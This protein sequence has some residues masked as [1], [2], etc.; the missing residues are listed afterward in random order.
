[1]PRLAEVSLRDTLIPSGTATIAI[2][3]TASEDAAL[4]FRLIRTLVSSARSGG[5]ISAP[6]A[7]SP[8]RFAKSCGKVIQAIL[9]FSFI[10]LNTPS[11]FSS[12][13]IESEFPIGWGLAKFSGSFVSRGSPLTSR[14][15][16]TS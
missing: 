5:V 1:M 10:C 4:S 11:S 6:F 13:V 2:A 15:V 16:T 8:S 9:V 14:K 3:S 12:K 7:S